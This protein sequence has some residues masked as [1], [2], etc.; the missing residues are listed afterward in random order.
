MRRDKNLQLMLLREFRDRETPP[1]LE[2]RSKEERS[3]NAAL[4]VE[5][6][7]VEGTTMVNHSGQ[8]VGA[9]FRRITNEGHDL[10]DQYEVIPSQDLNNVRPAQSPKMKVFISHSSE[11]SEVAELL[12]SLLRAAMSLPSSSIRCTSVDGYRLPVGAK[13]D[14]QLRNEVRNSEVFIGIITPASISSAYVLF[15][16]GARWGAELPLFPVTSSGASS[17]DLRGPLKG[18]NALDLASPPQV[19]QL[20]SDVASSLSLSQEPSTASIHK[21]V[22]QL[23]SI[24]QQA[25]NQSSVTTSLPTTLDISSEIVLFSLLNNHSGTTANAIGS[26]RGSRVSKVDAL[27]IIREFGEY[28]WLELTPDENA[29]DFT[30]R[31]S[32]K[33]REF[34][35]KYEG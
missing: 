18:M 10:L 16:L 4:L 30:C 15:E 33:G 9:I 12:I 21:S 2:S 34:A 3:Y 35:R 31:L 1:E 24:A 23:C 11:D 26:A 20:I 28:G 25:Q 13:T 29:C 27:S 7:Y 17:H 32:S 19:F 22:Q 5:G 8:Y 14:D 6:G